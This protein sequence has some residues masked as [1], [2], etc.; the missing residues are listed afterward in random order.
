MHT[1]IYVCAYISTHIFMHAHRLTNI[2]IYILT[3]I[4]MHI[5]PEAH[6]H[7]HIHTHTQTHTHTSV[8]PTCPIYN[9]C[10]S[11]V[12][13]YTCVCVHMLMLLVC[14]YTS[15]HINMD[16]YRFTDCTY[17]GVCKWYICLLSQM[18]HILY[19]VAVW[20]TNLNHVCMYTWVKIF[21]MC[22][23]VYI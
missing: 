22:E 1:N 19:Y 3:I 15:R 11:H 7:T 14:L 9:R 16:I 20:S 10:I 13:T 17:L 12:N 6:S 4:H 18:K 23:C 5:H 2:N 21:C 8:Y